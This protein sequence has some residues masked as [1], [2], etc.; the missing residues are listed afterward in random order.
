MSE[1]HDMPDD[2]VERLVADH[3]RRQAQ[4]LDVGASLQR[5]R[6]GMADESAL[7]GN[8]PMTTRRTVM[9]R[10]SAAAAAAVL[11]VASL[12][13]FLN[14]AS[15]SPASL[16]RDAQ[17]SMNLPLDRCF[18][19]EIVYEPQQDATD[20]MASVLTR[21]WT[22]KLWTRGDRFWIESANP[23]HRWAWGRDDSGGVW[24]TDGLNRGLYFAPDEVPP[25]LSSGLNLLGI[26][27][28]TMLA[29]FLKD[30]EL[31][32]DE[33]VDQ[34]HP[35]GTVIHATV[36][37]GQAPPELQQAALQIDP[38]T[39]EL[40]RM[41]LDRTYR[42]R[43]WA[44]VNLTLLETRPRDDAK[45]GIEGHLRQPYEVFTR[46]HRPDRRRQIMIRYFGDRAKEWIADP[47]TRK[48]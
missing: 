39:G 48:G 27:F 12:P 47:Q 19:V 42:G 2:E 7:A 28:R 33:L 30:F 34:T 8:L 17:R 4:G 36:K 23:E 25:P 1:H 20:D 31:R 24:M 46:E 14:P 22:T 43:K 44:T 9:L 10:W 40:R 32:R 15:A 37:P 45:Y 11:V 29:G 18:L 41:T 38:H 5:L 16:L 6:A 3:L 35:G 26:R 21:S 13:A